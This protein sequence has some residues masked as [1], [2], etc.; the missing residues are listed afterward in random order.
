METG[1]WVLITGMSGS[2]KTLVSHVF[3]DLGYFCV[4]N[5]PPQLLPALVELSRHYTERM[6]YVALVVD[7]RC[8]QMLDH[9]LPGVR[10][11]AEQGIPTHI[12]FLDCSDE[13]LVQRFKETRRKHPLFHEHPTILQ[14]IRAE[15]GL[16]EELRASADRVIDTSMLLPHELRSIIETEY[17]IVERIAGIAVNVVSFGFKYGIPP[18]ADLVFDVRFL[19]NPHY[20]SHLRPLDGRDAPIRNYVLS[21]PLAGS[22]IQRLKDLIEFTLPQYIREGKAYLTIAIGCTGGRHRSVVVAEQVV[23]FLREKG[24]RVNLQH[25]DVRRQP[26]PMPETE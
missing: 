17:G 22:F 5:L 25:R 24:Y 19:A 20:V 8:G 7:T 2:G 11:V 12:L 3:E 10:Q 6:R 15:R 16:L 13:M 18:E 14:S 1:R 4:D 26:P 23:Q 21:D 9:L